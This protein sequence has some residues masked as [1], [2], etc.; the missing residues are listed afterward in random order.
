LLVNEGF[1]AEFDDAG[2]IGR[3]YARADEAGVPLGVAVDYDTLSDG[4]VT[5]RDRDSWRQVRSSL[6]NLPQLLE[7]YFQGK[8]SFEDMGTLVPASS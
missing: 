2:S 4:S 3:R 6:K 8:I 1:M 5:I 7:R